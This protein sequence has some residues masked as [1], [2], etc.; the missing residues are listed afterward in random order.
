MGSVGRKKRS[1]APL[2]FSENC[3]KTPLISN[4]EQRKRTSSLLFWWW[5]LFLAAAALFICCCI[6]V[7]RKDG[8]NW[9]AV[10]TWV[11]DRLFTAAATDGEGVLSVVLSLLLLDSNRVNFCG[12]EAFLLP[13]LLVLAP[14]ICCMRELT[15]PRLSK[16]CCCCRRGSAA[17][18]IGCCWGLICGGLLLSWGWER[19]IEV[20]LPPFLSS[21]PGDWFC[22]RARGYE[23]KF[24]QM[25]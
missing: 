12:F 13:L 17:L 25:K 7:D 15:A 8:M 10:A 3:L 18:R 4:L 24:D 6:I 5:W 23:I 1:H 22:W 2:P 9:R 20:L 11:R 16:A 21:L 19:F 14:G